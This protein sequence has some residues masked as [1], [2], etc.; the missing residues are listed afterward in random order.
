SLVVPCRAAVEPAPPRVAGRLPWVGAGAQLL[1]NPA[2]FFVEMRRTLGDTYLVDAF[3]YRL[4]CVFSP[5]GVRAL[6][7]VPED[8]ATFG[9]ATRHLLPP[10]L[11][12]ELFEGRR[13]T[14]RTL[15]GGDDVERY[16]ANLEE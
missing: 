3:G 13:T 5:A 1:R 4:F 15:F 12:P 6:Y 11:P 8:P 10:K 2:G 9:P 7:A 16:L 14:A